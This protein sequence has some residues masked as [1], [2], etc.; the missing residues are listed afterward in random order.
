MARHVAAIEVIVQKTAADCGIAALAMLTGN[1]YVN[2]SACV[3]QLNAALANGMSLMQLRRLSKS[4]GWPLVKKEFMDD[5]EQIGLVSLS[6][7]KEAGHVVVYAEG[8]IIDP[9]NGLLWLDVQA[10]LKQGGWQVDCMLI[11]K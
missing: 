4:I 10:Y 1:T 7:G 3:L 5:G 11:P 2:V 8:I 9:A 6:R